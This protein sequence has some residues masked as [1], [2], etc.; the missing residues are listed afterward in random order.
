MVIVLNSDKFE[1]P[2]LMSHYFTFNN[3]LRISVFLIL[4]LSTCRC[5]QELKKFPARE[6][7]PSVDQYEI[8]INASPNPLRVLYLGCGHLVIQY[9]NE[10][11]ITDPYFSTQPF[12]P[13][14]IRIHPDDYKKYAEVV[15]RH[16][17]DLTKA[18]SVWLAHTHYDHMMDIPLLLKENQ[19]SRTAK[20]Y[21]NEFGDNILQNF[22]KPE[23]YHTILP[24][25]MFNP[26][27]KN[28]STLPWLDASPSIR[29][30]PILSDHAPHLKIGPIKI[31]LMRGKLKSE[32]FRK[33]FTEVSSRTR[34][35]QWRE[36]CTYSFLVDFMSGENIEYRLFIQTSASHYPLG[37][38]P[39]EML[40]QRAVDVA[41][42]CVASTN[43]AKPY[44]SD[45]IKQIH[46]KKVVLI[47]WEDFFLKTL[48]F[49]S[50]KL[51]RLT[52]FK[53]VDKQL[54]RTGLVPLKDNFVMP[55]PGTMITI[56]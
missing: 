6:I 35:G 34:Q 37:M 11:M 25:E 45:I 53:K 23:Q 15:S 10:S 43:F 33:N 24:S 12:K 5:A 19:L 1:R 30:M 13:G 39:P 17:V 31:H 32:Y 47:H 9:R 50:A 7:I 54:R 46:P 52:N 8:N 26:E 42:L 36:G 38:P 48:D 41:F 18:S 22:I 49:D 14:K 2:H 27:E 16:G 21:G 28:P 20:I 3:R 51:V 29:V 40:K 56:K 44:P 4:A 55:R